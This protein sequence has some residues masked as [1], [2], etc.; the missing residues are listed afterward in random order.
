VRLRIG[1]DVGGTF[2]HAV[3]LDEELNLVASAR[4]LT[5]HRHPLGVAQ[6]IREVLDSLLQEIPSPG[7]VESIAHSTTQATNALLEGRFAPVRLLVVAPGVMGLLARVQ[8]GSGELSV[9]E[10]RL[11]YSF[12]LF[13]NFSELERLGDISDPETLTVLLVPF[14][15]EQGLVEREFAAR[16]TGMMAASGVAPRL[17]LKHRAL[18]A[19]ANAALVPIMEGTARETERVCRE[20]MP[21]V[22]LAVLRSDGGVMGARELSQSPVQAIY[23]GPAA[24]ASAA[25]GYLGLGDGIFIEVGGTSTD[26]TLIE[27]GQVPRSQITIGGT[28]LLVE[29]LDLRTVG[30]G[31]G[32]LLSEEGRLGPHSAHQAGL[33][34]FA[35]GP[36]ARLPLSVSTLELTEHRY[37]VFTDG[38]GERFGLTLSDIS[39][40]LG[41]AEK[42]G[43]PEGERMAAIGEALE[44]AQQ[45][46]GRPAHELASR[47]LEGAVKKLAGEIR[48]LVQDY[49]LEDTS[50]RLLIGGGGGAPYLIS[51]LASELGMGFRLAPHTE[52]ISAIG[53]ALAVRSVSLVREAADPTPEL[54]RELSREAA[55]RLGAESEEA[56]RLSFAYSPSARTLTLQAH[57]PLHLGRGELSLQELTRL[58]AQFFPAG[59]AELVERAGGVV[60][61]GEGGRKGRKRLVVLDPT[62]RLLARLY[63]YRVAPVREVGEVLGLLDENRRFGDSGGRIPLAL[64]AWRGCLIDLRSLPELEQVRS[65]LELQM[66][67]EGEGLLFLRPV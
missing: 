13:P 42:A 65:A 37:L 18:T 66:K 6:G 54:Y 51:P 16:H 36:K 26:I 8:L 32:S 15:D 62:G 46:V 41:T 52:V 9:G 34:Y 31:G 25:V 67:G 57:L 49:Q 1:I 5:T 27:C 58:A 11:L 12:H 45:V 59:R 53:A 28:R 14:P 4:T 43:E 35:F 39:L 40:F 38:A 47:S 56:V 24:G 20:L 64:V 23:S 50:S 21:G 17:G 2:T 30:I 60:V 19:L 48:G 61:F 29:G 63:R 7:R 44:L 3:A 33:S 22:S 55:R 10:A